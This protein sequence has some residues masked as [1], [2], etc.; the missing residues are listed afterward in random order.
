M[1]IKG[2]NAGPSP[3]AIW[4]ERD[5]KTSFIEGRSFEKLILAEWIYLNM[6]QFW[7]EIF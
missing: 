1:E 2:V 4:N 5:A 7:S 6:I 3:S